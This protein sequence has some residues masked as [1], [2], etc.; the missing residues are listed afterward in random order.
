MVHAGP[1]DAIR[2]PASPRVVL[3]TT[4]VVSDGGGPGASYD[5]RDQYMPYF[6]AE[7]ET[8]PPERAWALL[9]LKEWK[10]EEPWS[11]Y[12]G[13]KSAAVRRLATSPVLLKELE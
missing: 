11:H 2:D 1:R 5:V 13:D 8:M 12:P 6:L 9:N 7:D 3:F 4:F 10:K